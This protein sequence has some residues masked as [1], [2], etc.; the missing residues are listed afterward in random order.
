MAKAR[1]PDDELFTVAPAEFVRERHR[2][3]TRLRAG[4]RADD[5]RAV[6]RLRKP[7]VALWAANQA[8]RGA[9]AAVGRLIQAVDR[10]KPAQ[11]AGRQGLRDAMEA[12]RAA[13]D[14]LIAVARRAIGETGLRTNPELLG[15]VSATLLGAAI[16]AGARDDLRA[17]RLLDERPAPGFEA[18]GDAVA[19]APARPAPAAPARPRPPS[20]RSASAD[21]VVALD[22]AIRAREARRKAEAARDELADRA[23][24]LDAAAQGRESEARAAAEALAALRRQVRAAVT[25][26][27][28][29]RHAAATARREAERMRRDA[30]RAARKLSGPRARRSR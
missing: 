13:L 12:Q 19:S 8:A 20:K 9:A 22:E 24:A 5:A 17:G 2:V 14:E 23:A 6:A 16:D 25:R 26:V 11:L 4:G 10:V 3:A 7:T 15:R 27:T 28:Q 18:F 30:E 1:A 29:T 21:A